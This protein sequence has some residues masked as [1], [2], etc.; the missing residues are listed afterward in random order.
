MSAAEEW[1]DE[2]LLP[3][4]LRPETPSRGAKKNALPVVRSAKQQA[5]AAKRAERAAEEAELRAAQD[6]AKAQ[7]ARLAQVVNLHIA[8]YS[9]ADIG[10]S[11]GA[12]AEEVD[13][14]LA[15]D[16]QRYVRNQP[17]L[18]TYVRNYISGKYT[19]LLD[20]VWDRATDATHQENLEAQDR[21]LRILDR[22]GRLHGAEAPL[23]KEVH[24]EAAPEA[25]EKLVNALAQGQGL[26][27]DDSIFDI[28]DGEVVEEAVTQSEQA[29][30]DS[31]EAVEHEQDGDGDG[32]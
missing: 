14:M 24:I 18:R 15:Q 20:T 1:E 7:A 21:A 12:T 16:T 27:Y 29:L 30:E 9:L 10:A 26:G 32:F 28:V 23:Q 4:E 6:A 13:R 5:A 11:I 22:M 17:A 19:K 25:V 2:D 8:G 3:D 31:S